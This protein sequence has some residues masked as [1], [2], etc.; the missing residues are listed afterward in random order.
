MP[1]EIIQ[2]KKGNI[3]AVPG[4]EAAG[5][6]CGLKTTGNRDLA[7]IYT[8]NRCTAAGVFTQNRFPA[9][10]VLY[11]QKALARNPAGIRAVAINSGCANACTGEPGLANAHQMAKLAG[12][13]LGVAPESVLIMSTGVIGQPLAME[14]VAQGIAA[15]ASALSA[16]GGHEAARAI[17]TTDTRPKAI[18]VRLALAGRTVTI[19]GMCKG[20]GM[21]HPNMAT[22][23]GLVATDAVVEA[24]LLAQALRQAVSRSFN[25]ITVDGDTSTNDTVLLLANGASGVEIAS[26]DSLAVFGNALT[27]VCTELAQMIVRD[28][29]GATKFVE[30]VVTGARAESE[31]LAIAQ[32]IATSALVKTAFAGSDA[33]WGR[34]LAAAGRAGVSFAQDRV[35]LWVSAGQTNSVQLVAGGTPLPYSEAEATFVFSQPEFQVHLDLDLGDEK[36]TVWTCDLTHDYVTI[37]A[38]YRT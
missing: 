19:G 25:R 12:E 17:M 33:N 13:A 28:G 23:L 32:T 14:K 11:D 15:A 1:F 22:M 4:F 18:A 2:G 5:V 10:P 36:A 29:E 26:P 21:I 30:L 24:D 34:I 35:A 37:N 16:T 7:L 27:A 3:T 31:A 6:A 8:P 38:D 20:A 9:A